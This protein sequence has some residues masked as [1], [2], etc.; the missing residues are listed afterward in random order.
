MAPRARVLTNIHLPAVPGFSIKTF[1]DY[2]T[3]GQI[4]GKPLIIG[5][6]PESDLLTA[7]ADTPASAWRPEFE[8]R[9]LAEI[10]SRIPA[11]EK[12]DILIIASPEYL[13]VPLDVERFP[14][15]KALL[16]TDWNVC[17]RFLPNL[18][19]L[20]D[21]CFTDWPGYRLLRRAGVGNVHHQALFGHDPAVFRDLGRHRNLDVSFCG[22]LNS[23]LHGERNRLLARLA[24]W[25]V[26]RSVHVRQAFDSDY[27]EVL[28]R[29]R[30]VFNYSIRRE[31]NMRLFE[32]MAC[33]AVPLV[34][35]TNQEA[36]ILFQEGK[37]YFK[38]P[39]GGLE[40]ALDRLLADPARI[41][42]VAEA[43]REAVRGQTKSEQIRAALDTILR[44]GSGVASLGVAASP[45][46]LD[47][48]RVLP[49]LRDPGVVEARRDPVAAAAGRKALIKLRVLGKG[50]T[51]QEA[52]QEIM[53]RS[54]DTPGIAEE[55]LPGAFLSALERHPGKMLPTIDA[56]LT[57]V[58]PQ[59]PEPLLGFL[60]M[61]RIFRSGAW[62]DAA[63]AA[64]ALL[65]TLESAAYGHDL[66]D[67]FHP[68]LDLGLGMNTDLNNAYR[69]DLETAS[70][71][72]PGKPTGY[73]ALLRALALACQGHA[74]LALGR[75]AEALEALR[76]IRPP[77]INPV[78]GLEPAPGSIP[79]PGIIPDPGYA[80]VDAHGDLAEAQLA[81]GDAAGSASTLREWFRLK[82]LDT[83]VWDKVYEGLQKTGDKNGLVAFLREI[84]VYAGAF[85]DANQARIISDLLAR[86]LA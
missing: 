66:Y 14:G 50:Y 68:P 79:R 30:L 71:A 25:G 64:Q 17:L 27:V 82:P 67:Q 70:G 81:L 41:A 8:R 31:A 73:P 5:A 80:S 3:P 63:A 37:H 4:L 76:K 51:M 26:G 43:G 42:A 61:K 74:L 58:L 53:Q 28:N 38:Y 77:D 78:P 52:L 69:R 55:A 35:E 32:A 59:T 65:V 72:F 33:G 54:G 7:G 36:P 46:N 62:T 48:T 12:P 60:K 56:L 29:S 20:F 45:E 9:S 23:G 24:L 86:E 39:L 40:A 75:P 10:L 44:A 84:S 57:R 6:P 21:F 11:S 85:L 15:A 49:G 1:G 22:N 83:K 47:V 18:C 34:E 2:L 19:P 16:I 13:P